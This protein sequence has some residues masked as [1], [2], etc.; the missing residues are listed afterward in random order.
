MNQQLFM[1]IFDFRQKQNRGRENNCLSI[2]L[3]VNLTLL[4]SKINAKIQTKC[5]IIEW[6]QIQRLAI[7]R[8]NCIQSAAAADTFANQSYDAF[9]SLFFFSSNLVSNASLTPLS[10]F[11]IAFSR[12]DNNHFNAVNHNDIVYYVRCN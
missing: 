2:K 6:K 1:Q 10:L 11:R 9:F 5:I 4:C 8:I 3:Y 7:G 12:I